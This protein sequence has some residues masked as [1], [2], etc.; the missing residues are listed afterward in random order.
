MVIADCRVLSWPELRHFRRTCELDDHRTTS[1]A[2]WLPTDADCDAAIPPSSVPITEIVI[3]AV[4][5]TFRLP[6]ILEIVDRSQEK[7]RVVVSLGCEAGA[8]TTACGKKVFEPP[9]GVFA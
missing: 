8:E 7:A 6:Q 9:I 1:A 5:G 2:V 4:K 3:P